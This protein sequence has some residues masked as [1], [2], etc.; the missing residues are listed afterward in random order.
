MLK[1]LLDEFGLVEDGK[2]T[3]LRSNNDYARWWDDIA[4][5]ISKEEE[6]VIVLRL[7]VLE[8]YFQNLKQKFG[9][10]VDIQHVSPISIWRKTIGFELPSEVSEKQA[11]GLFQSQDFLSLTTKDNKKL[12]TLCILLG[13]TGF[14]DFE[15]EDFV[16]QCILQN[17]EGQFATLSSD[18]IQEMIKALPPE[19]REFWRRLTEE[20]NTREILVSA[21]KSLIVKNYPH[22]SS[23]FN[24][25]FRQSLTYSSFDFP[26]Q[27]SEYLDSEFKNDIKKY[28]DTLESQKVLAII[29][30]KLSEEW[31]VVIK[32]LQEHPSQEKA[33]ISSLLV[34]ALGS[35]KLYREIYNFEPVSPPEKSIKS[36]EIQN[37]LDQYFAFYLYSRRIGKPEYT[38]ELSNIFED[39]IF[40]H[41]TKLD[42]FFTNNSILTVRQRTE[43]YLKGKHKLLLLVVDGLSYSYHEE[44]NRIF[45][46]KASFAFSTLPTITEINKRRILSG[47]LDL[48][49]TYGGITE[50]LY[51]GFRWKETDSNKQDLGDFL[52]EELDFYIYWENRFDNYIHEPMTFAK[53]FSD[54]VEI[55]ERL[56]QHV[57]A[58]VDK[59]G[60][61]LLT[62][63]HGYTTLP[64]IESNKIKC[65]EMSKITHDR[66]LEIDDANRNS[67]PF[68]QVLV[69]GEHL[70]VAKGYGYFNSFPKGATHGGATPEE[71]TVPFL[72]VEKKRVDLEQMIFKLQTDEEYRRRR[73]QAVKLIVNNP[74]VEDVE[75]SSIRFMPRILKLLS[76]MPALFPHGEYGIDAE[77]DLVM[78][79]TAECKIFVE[80]QVAEKVYKNSFSIQTKGAMT[81][82]ADEWE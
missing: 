27:L 50:R 18:A 29:S 1:I 46:T 74:N 42:Q 82:K 77:L 10:K 57:K 37:W 33:V 60:I 35:P 12:A 17:T 53:R 25:N 30:G 73:K 59:G 64:H 56:S 2:T 19:K 5:S 71:I 80:Y 61:V 79:K 55:L 70:A 34:R 81:E 72:V 49:G 13:I 28:L 24:H 7:P 9:S 66:V 21:M 3:V 62:G 41:F 51:N 38:Q 32:G 40:D 58:F 52:R 69:L 31:G 39:F 20:K 22:D 44:L 23:P 43:K 4:A 67:I 48:N 8:S 65:P 63:D 15:S 76:P 14:S 16:E 54:H 6:R 75:I 11:V 78:V 26:Q 45:G 68:Q 36:E 47:L